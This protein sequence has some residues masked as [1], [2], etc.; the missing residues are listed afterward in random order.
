[1]NDFLQIAGPVS[2]YAVLGYIIGYFFSKLRATTRF[3][4]IARYICALAIFGSV[5]VLIFFLPE[6]AGKKIGFGLVILVYISSVVGGVIGA[7]IITL[8]LL[9]NH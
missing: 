6:F 5:S 3:N 9:R 8:K 4:R 1:M 7:A 2:L